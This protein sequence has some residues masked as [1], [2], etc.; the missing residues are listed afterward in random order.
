[1]KEDIEI[2]QKT[3][4]PILKKA[5]VLQSSIFGSM[6]R[7]EANENSDIDILVELP[8]D[9]TIFDLMELEDK[10]R[11]ALGKKVDVVTYRS[12]H[13][14]LRDRVLREHVKIL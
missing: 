6:A 12:L 8:N 9:K 2:I 11:V 3:I 13:H 4:N 1:M 5:G 7:G 14:L 10:L